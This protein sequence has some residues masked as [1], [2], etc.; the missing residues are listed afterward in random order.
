MTLDLRSL[1]GRLDA[2]SRRALEGAAGLCLSRSHYEVELEHWLVKL[3]ED[4]PSDVPRILRHFAVDPE[5]ALRDLN[6]ALDGFK[7]GNARR[8]DLSP[9][10]EQLAREGWVQA[11][12]NFAQARVRSGAIFLAALADLR[13]R[14]RLVDACGELRNVNPE[15]LQN[16]LLKIV[17]GSSE[18]AEVTAAEAGAPARELAP[19]GAAPTRTPALDQYTIDL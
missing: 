5:R 14:R 9:T 8:P 4:G 18:D 12:I 10:I 17:A 1:I 6:R 19:A 7:S 15:V 11:S 3:L 2:T 13:L 16:E